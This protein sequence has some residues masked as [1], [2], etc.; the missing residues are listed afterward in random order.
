M[1]I[2]IIMILSHVY[3]SPGSSS[4]EYDSP[5]V[6]MQEFASEKDCLFAGKTVLKYAGSMSKSINAVCVQ[7]GGMSK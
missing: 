4:Y 2:L 3:S 7:K 1:Y 5:K 6:T